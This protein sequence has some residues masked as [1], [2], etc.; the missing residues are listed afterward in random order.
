MN[1]KAS[2]FIHRA[3][4]ERELKMLNTGVENDILQKEVDQD[5][6]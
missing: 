3:L 6:P 4:C 5:V 2:I 1:K